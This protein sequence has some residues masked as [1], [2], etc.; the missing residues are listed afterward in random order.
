METSHV[1]NVWQ[2]GLRGVASIPRAPAP[3]V[4]VRASGTTPSSSLLSSSL[5]SPS[6]FLTPS[7]VFATYKGDSGWTWRESG[8]CNSG[9]ALPQPQALRGRVARPAS[10]ARGADARGS[11]CHRTKRERGW[12][13]VSGGIDGDAGTRRFWVR[14]EIFHGT[15]PWAERQRDQI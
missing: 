7:G 6:R 2:A 13:C 9:G 14:G 1:L 8:G 10:D 12:G 15:S 4:F 11:Q 5:L 3:L